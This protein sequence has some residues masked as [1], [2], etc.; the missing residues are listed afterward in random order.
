MSFSLTYGVQV[1]R[2]GDGSATIRPTRIQM[3]GGTRTAARVLRCSPMTV[4][5]MIVEGEIPARKLR[6]NRRNSKF[7]VCMTSVYEM[8]EAALK[9]EK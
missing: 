7:V 8:V 6:P 1:I 2:H 3:E 5:R 4:R 9:A